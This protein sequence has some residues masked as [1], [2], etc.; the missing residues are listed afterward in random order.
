MWSNGFR[1][2]FFALE[3]GKKE[4]KLRGGIFRTD[5]KLYR[6]ALRVNNG[7]QARVL[8][9]SAGL[10]LAIGLWSLKSRCNYCKHQI[11]RGEGEGSMAV[12]RM[13]AVGALW[14]EV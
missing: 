5:G 13:R 10:G 8:L 14:L 6:S 2:I 7:I 9:K 4:I 1:F 12:T 3:D 11:C